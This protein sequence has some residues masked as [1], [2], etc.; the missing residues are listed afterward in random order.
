MIDYHKTLLEALKPIL[1]TYYEMAL[2]SGLKTPC[3][4]YIELNNATADDGDSLGYSRLTYQIKV[5]ATDIGI[6]QKYALKV[7]EAMRQL[8]F[9]RTASGELFD[10][11]SAMIQKVMTYEAL[12]LEEYN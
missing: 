2:H 10:Y 12:A 1:P 5:W 3:I 4:S 7:D 9:S 6:I 11:N 8:G